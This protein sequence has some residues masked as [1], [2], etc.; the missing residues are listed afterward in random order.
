[1]KNPTSSN[2]SSI[3]RSNPGGFTLIELLV[4]IAIIS[5]LSAMLLPALTK[6]KEKAQG[7]SCLNNLK[8]LMLSW[9]MYNQD[10]NEKICPSF[11]GGDAQGGNFP[12]QLGPGWVEGWLDWTTGSDNTNIAFLTSEKY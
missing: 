11:H 6:A 1:M 9:Q 2:R 8:Q 7:I 3:L 5:I 4:V 12:P 10:N